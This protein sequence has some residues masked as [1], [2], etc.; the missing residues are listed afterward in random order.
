MNKG[1]I[2]IFGSIFLLFLCYIS[3]LSQ[4][5]YKL[6]VKLQ[7]QQVAR[8]AGPT[9]FPGQASSQLKGM[10]QLQAMSSLLIEENNE[11]QRRGASSK[12]GIERIYILSFQTLESL[13]E[14]R[15]SLS[16]YSNLEYFEPYPEA[17]PL[18]IPN[19]PQANPNSGQQAY[20][21]AIDAYEGWD[22]QKGDT[23]V[24]V[25]VLDTGV[26]FDHEDLRDNIYINYADP[27]NGVDD[28]GDGFV[29]NYYGWDFADNTN[30]PKP[31]SDFHG[32]R[33]AGV[34]SASTNN[35]I[36]MAGLGYR[37]PYMA[38]K[39]FRSTNN[40]FSGGYEAI[41]YAAERGVKVL[42]LSWGGTGFS[43]FAEDV[44]RYAIEEKDVVLVAA[45]GNTPQE[46][47]FYPASYPG[48]ISVGAS[49]ITG[50]KAPW[51]TYNYRVNLLAPGIGIYST[52]GGN[53]YTND[54]GSSF[55]SPMV[56]G[57]AALLRAQYPQWN[58]HQIRERL[59][60]SAKDVSQIGSNSTFTGK[61]G[62]GIL[63]VGKA[64]NGS[65]SPAVR[66]ENITYTNGIGPYLFAGDTIHIFAEAVNYLD[67]VSDL[68]LEALVENENLIWIKKQHS[69]AQLQTL[70]R[71]ASTEPL[72]SFILSENIAEGSAIPLRISMKDGTTYA[73]YQYLP[74]RTESDYWT[75]VSRELAL[76][77]SSSGNLGFDADSLKRGQGLRWN[78]RL[79][80]DQPGIFI[81]SEDNRQVSNSIRNFAN[82]TK[83]TDLESLNRLRLSTPSTF[84]FEAGNFFRSKSE[85]NLP[86]HLE[87]KVLSDLQSGG[88]LLFEYRIE[89]QATENL[90]NTSFALTIPWRWYVINAEKLDSGRYIF[91]FNSNR[92]MGIQVFSRDSLR[93]QHFDMPFANANSDSSILSRERMK[94][95]ILASDSLD[96]ARENDF[97]FSMLSFFLDTLRQFMPQNIHWSI[98]GG[99][100]RE[101]I[102]GNLTRSANLLD[103]YLK[104]PPITEI[105]EYCDGDSVWVQ[106]TKSGAQLFAD[107][108]G[109]QLI[110]EQLLLTDL[111]SDT[112]LYYR[113]RDTYMQSR[114][115]AL[116]VK[117]KSITAEILLPADTIIL[118]SSNGSFQVQLQ[119]NSPEAD[120][121]S[122]DFGNGFASTRQNPITAFTE[123]GTYL[124]SL[125]VGSDLGCEEFDQKS[126][127]V[128][129]R[130]EKPIL[131]SQIWLCENESFGYQAPE[132]SEV[133]LLSS[134]QSI[135][136][137]RGQSLLF[138]PI[139]KDS[140]IHIALLKDEIKSLPV[141][142]EFRISAV[143]N[144]IIP[145]I[146]TSNLNARIP[147]ILK[148]KNSPNH[149]SLEMSE[150]EQIVS[151]GAQYQFAA[152]SDRNYSF[153]LIS[154]D[155]RSTC[156]D[157]SLL[158][159][160]T[161]PFPTEVTLEA[162]TICKD[163]SY[164][165]VPEADLLFNFYA[166]DPSNSDILPSARG[167]QLV[168]NR[169]KSDTSVWA[170]TLSLQGEQSVYRLDL[171]IERLEATITLEK[172]TFNINLNRQ[173]SAR[174]EG[175]SFR[176]VSWRLNNQ[177]IGEG[178]EIQFEVPDVGTYV[179]QA[180]I[181]SESGCSYR[182]SI[183][184]FAYNILQSENE[185]HIKVF[186]NPSRGEISVLL[187]PLK[188]LA[189]LRVI[190][191]SGKIHF[192]Q[193]IRANQREVE[194]Q[195]G[196]IPAGKYILEL[197]TNQLH[198]RESIILIR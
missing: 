40:S 162:I 134:D 133:L 111:D 94:D 81:S 90:N 180:D 35:Q 156:A 122:W 184:F 118:P 96:F 144:E 6:V 166:D 109:L 77:L 5:T 83:F 41:I 106:S 140:T 186:P 37:S 187:P 194:L 61:I 124:I 62:N 190:D 34:S 173:N 48:V 58:A 92:W 91:E 158:I 65:L 73:D 161:I 112:L 38:L 22:I 130:P 24:I 145:A 172:D 185:F 139:A 178:E 69:I 179:L 198:L 71:V 89:N 148:A 51:A 195:L 182:E 13:E 25:G 192:S 54:S 131:A 113:Y 63:Q 32:T 78:N 57:A 125:M 99:F 31:G 76:T 9:F 59:R 14:A 67:P 45:A 142:V 120:T 74:L 149:W 27:I 19:D 2:H 117:K 53:A 175:A 18:H 20:L 183:S 104:S 93:M 146:D 30:N 56:A 50:E 11:N 126:I 3:A 135:E 75:A 141:Q 114:M 197:K 82:R 171:K 167:H 64:L 129:I 102:I 70:Q 10:T 181:T 80:A 4:D 1:F 196:G 66:L 47:N 177:L 87:Q 147:I 7:D 132:G 23:N 159:L 85:R 174:I 79:M 29:D 101:E 138:G 143:E 49:T 60:I 136:Y 8:M 105:V 44:I 115:E 97:N 55:S 84:P 127:T 165:W 137:F 98:T 154:V 153:Q 86:I 150:N 43:Q 95:W 103:V 151:T 46:V 33:V 17:I 21:S 176:T 155:T 157:T 88:F 170:T 16:I 116:Q 123:P 15:K 72:F 160:Q 12:V 189:F 39:I 68:V 163:L 26:D 188:E 52:T 100:S 191:M 168:F 169:L 152:D 164:T 108:A 28:D 128:Q 121:W 36:G 110:G 107:P 119:S 42:N 193:S